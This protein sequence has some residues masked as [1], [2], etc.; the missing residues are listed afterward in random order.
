MAA[1]TRKGARPSF[2][3][4]A[5]PDAGRA[6]FEQLVAAAQARHPHV[7][8]GRFGADM[9]VTLTNDCP[10]TFWLQVPPGNS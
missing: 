7:A 1:D 4:A 6:I 3:S 5:P 9:K 2:S 8:C 10:V